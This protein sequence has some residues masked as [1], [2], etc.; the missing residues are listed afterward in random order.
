MKLRTMKKSARRAF[1]LIELLV[2]IAIIAVLIALLLPAVQSAREAARRAQCVNNLKQI[3]LASH[4]YESGNGTFPI[5]WMGSAPPNTYPGLPPCYTPNPIGHTAFVYI[6]P[7]M[8]GGNAYNS[9]N[10]VRVYNSVSNNT[11]SSAKLASYI[12]PSDTIAAPDPNGDFP[13][14]QASYAASEG[15]QEQLVFSWANTTPPDPTGQYVQTCNQGPGDGVFGPDYAQKIANITDGL[16]NTFFFGETSRFVNENGASN[17]YF[18]YAAGFWQ[19]PPWTAKFG[20]GTFWPFD[21]RLTGLATCIAR[22]N[23]PADTTGALFQTCFGCGAFYP[24]DWANLSS[25]PAGPCYP[26]TNWGQLS[27]RS[28]H[29]GGG[30]FAFAD[31]S[32]KFIKN[33]IAL[34]TYRGLATRATAEVISAD[35]Y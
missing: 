30:N 10:I 7:Y 8:E 9:W 5:G 15:L 20:K 16:S 35:Q 21:I 24:P 6:L 32:V 28:L 22:L 34:Q 26:C 4:N 27:F 14:A 33:S 31:G 17:F 18:N 23:A 11:G 19:G 1:T 25:T 29:P 12:C 13:A 2:V 3:A